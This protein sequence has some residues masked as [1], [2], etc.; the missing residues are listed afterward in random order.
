VV[1]VEE[2][3]IPMVVQEDLEEVVDQ[4]QILVDQEHQDKEIQEVQELLQITE[5]QVEAVDLVL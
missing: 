3:I 1:V 5:L 2:I 4:D